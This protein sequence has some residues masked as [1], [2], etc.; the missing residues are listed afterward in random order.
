MLDYC[1]AFFDFYFHQQWHEADVIRSEQPD[2]A[3]KNFRASKL[4]DQRIS[5]LTLIY[6]FWGSGTTI[7]RQ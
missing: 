7:I 1:W 3:F 6:H 4:A 5:F 2:Q